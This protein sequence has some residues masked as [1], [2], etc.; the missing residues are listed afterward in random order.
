MTDIWSFLLQTLTASGAAALLLIVKAMFRDKL[1]P[2]WQ[3]AVWGVLAVVLLLPA[4]RGGRYVLLNWPMLIETAKSVLTGDFGTLTHVIAPVPLPSLTAPKTAAD[5]LYLIYLAG[6]VIL[7]ARYL[8]SY[9]L[10]RMALKRG[11]P[12]QNERVKAVGS[13]YH[14]PVCPAVEVDGLPTAFICG[15]FKPVL[16]LPAGTETDEKVILHELLHLKYRDVVWGLAICLFRCLHWCNPLL[17]LCADWAGNDLESLCDQRVLERLEGEERRDYGRILLSMADEKYARTPGTS[18]AANGG[19]NIRRRIEAIARFKRYPAGMALVSVCVALVLAFPLMIGARAE[20]V[21]DNPRGYFFA[22]G[23]TA[24]FASARTVYCTTYA[25]AFDA[26][27]KAVLQEN[28]LYRAMCTTL[29]EQND[30]AAN[31]ETGYGSWD[32]GLPMPAIAQSGYYIYN[33]TRLEDGAWKGLLAVELPNEQGGSGNPLRLAVQTVRVEQEGG[34]WVAL[35]QEKFWII[36]SRSSALSIWGCEE[37]PARVY[38]AQYGDFTIQIRWQIVAQVSSQVRYDNWFGSSYT[39]DTVPKPHGTF[40]Q[41]SHE[42]TIYA[43]YTGDP[44]DK[45]TYTHI[46][47]ASIPIYGDERRHP[48]VG[49][50][51]LNVQSSGSSTNGSSWGN[52]LLDGDWDERVTISGGGST[53][54]WERDKGCRIPAS[55]AA[56]LY[57]NYRTAAELTLL[58][59][60]GG[61]RIER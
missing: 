4:G 26:Y 52:Y 24:S 49:L 58:P 23:S 17:W 2:R 34:R 12:A 20:T 27:A 61:E 44:A 35:P 54:N 38:E 53:M 32:P 37:L 43:I 46:A 33:P 48:T 39:F 9:V 55:F 14:L 11:R 10:L 57:L 19:R 47:V 30:L 59:A 13:Q 29:S 36:D 25:G 3:F 41:V 50:D 5:W 1:S 7:L 18:S 21:R 15:V 28:A 45:E 6:V 22:D 31:G 40:D 60:E 56:T 8:V 51:Y 42:Q 16:A